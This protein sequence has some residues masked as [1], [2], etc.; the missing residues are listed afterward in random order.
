VEQNESAFAIDIAFGDPSR[1]LTTIDLVGFASARLLDLFSRH[2]DS[3]V[4]PPL[5][6]GRSLRRV[7]VRSEPHQN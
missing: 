2:A 3:R 4:A 1:R 5:A 7:N 6:L